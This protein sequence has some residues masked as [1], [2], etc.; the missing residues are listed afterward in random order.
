MKIINL[1][2]A[3][4]VVMVLAS[5]GSTYT[6]ITTKKPGTSAEKT[7]LEFETIKAQILTPN[8][9]G[10]H[11]D[12]ANYATVK[13]KLAA[14]DQQI[15][16]DNMPKKPRSPLSAELKKLLKDWIAAGAPEIAQAEPSKPPVQLPISPTPLE[17]IFA[18]VLAEVIQPKCVG[19]HSNLTEFK[20]VQASAQSILEQ[21]E[22]GKMPKNSSL[23]STEKQSLVEWLISAG[24]VSKPSTPPA[25]LS[26]NTIS[27][28]VITPHC[29]GCHKE[30]GSYEVVKAQTSSIHQEVE[31]GNMPM[32]GSLPADLK[33][34]LF[35]WITVGTPE[36]AGAT[37]PPTLDQPVD[38][39]A[40]NWK[41]INEKILIPMCVT[42]HS[43]DGKAKK[44][45]FST[46]AAFMAL[47]NLVIEGKKF[48]DPKAPKDSLLIIAVS[49]PNQKWP[50][51][52]LKSNIR[53]LNSEEIRVMTE[54]LALGM[55]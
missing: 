33:A 34:L 25:E 52:P 9:I 43:P 13:S 15:S 7:A 30:F 45:D 6:Q 20:N 22:S 35:N 32:G 18:G 8:C 49:D 19:C 1:F 2:G 21:V 48:A 16:S 29:I 40:P 36:I 41:A 23:S 24:A 44:Y 26:W 10:C 28:Q 55:P 53:Q 50:M 4:A 17:T 11:S 5:C 46:Q 31:S 14:I 37:S 39:L 12:L 47:S 54:W 27:S 3:I 51:P 42:C 38:K